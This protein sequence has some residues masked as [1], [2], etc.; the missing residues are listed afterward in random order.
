MIRRHNMISSIGCWGTGK[1]GTNSSKVW[2]FGWSYI[3]KSRSWIPTNPWYC[4]SCWGHRLG[5]WRSY[6]WKVNI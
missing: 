4:S 1:W 6:N 3:G 2:I 5:C